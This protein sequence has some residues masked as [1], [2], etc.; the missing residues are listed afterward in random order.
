M[1]HTVVATPILTAVFLVPSKEDAVAAVLPAPPSSTRL[2]HTSGSRGNGHQRLV[3]QL[4]GVIGHIASW[5]Y[6]CF[7]RDFMG[8]GNDGSNTERQVAIETQCCNTS[9][10]VDPAWY[11]DSA[12]TDYLTSNLDRLHMSKPYTGND[13]VHTIDGT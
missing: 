5:C 11:M 2:G 7:N 1:L 10:I 3:C 13:H 6:K 12:P 8:I 4:S 9:S